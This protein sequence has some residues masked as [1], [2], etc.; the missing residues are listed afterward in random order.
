[1]LKNNSGKPIPQGTARKESK[2]DGSSGKATAYISFEARGITPFPHNNP[3]PIA[4][5]G[6]SPPP[7]PKLPDRSKK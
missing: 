3:S 2:K 5:R 6:I 1:M 7:K 4:G